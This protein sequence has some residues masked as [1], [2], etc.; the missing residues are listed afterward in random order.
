MIGTK[1]V[2]VIPEINKYQRKIVHKICDLYSITREY[3]DIKNDEL[4]S[5]TIT[6]CEKSFIPSTTLDE[7]YQKHLE[8]LKKAS[9]GQSSNPFSNKKVLIKTRVAQPVKKEVSDKSENSDSSAS[10]NLPTS[11]LDSHEEFEKKKK[12][13][14]EEARDRILREAEENEKEIKQNSDSSSKQKKGK[15]YEKN[16]D[17][18]FDRSRSQPEMGFVNPNNLGTLNQMGQMIPP[19]GMQGMGY[20]PIYNQHYIP[21]QGYVG[22]NPNV[23]P[24]QNFAN[25]GNFGYPY[26]N[27]SSQNKPNTSNNYY[28]SFPTL[29][30]DANPKK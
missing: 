14:Y 11:N 15:R 3:I 1:N 2:E 30:R 28:Q 6:K 17:P 26:P 27:Q 18:D 22:S 13:E 25:M 10:Q 9:S 29:D 19:P 21:Y 16:Y 23:Y 12:K 5:I 4:G 24:T 20:Y 8:K 7:R